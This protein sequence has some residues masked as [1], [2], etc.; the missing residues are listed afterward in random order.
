[1]GKG[2][3]WHQ[4]KQPRSATSPAPAV[5]VT[6]RPPVPTVSA[7]SHASG[8][9]LEEPKREVQLPDT[10]AFGNRISTFSRTVL[11]RPLRSY[12]EQVAAHILRS[13][14]CELGLTFTVMMSRQMGKNE[15]SAHIEAYLLDK[16]AKQGGEIVKAAPTFRPQVTTSMMRLEALL[17]R[18]PRLQK[19]WRKEHGYTIA[20]GE[21]RALFFSGEPEAAAMGATA[22]L[23]LEIDEAQDI[24][25]QKYTRDFRP[26]ASSTNATTVLWGTAWT[27][28]SL[29]EATKR[30]NVHL[31]QLDPT[32]RRHFELDWTHGAAE[33]EKYGK[34]VR[35]EIDRLG[36]THPLIKTQYL[37][38]TLGDQGAFFTKDNLAQLNGTHRRM[39]VPSPPDGAGSYYVAGVDVAGP[40]EEAT[41][42]ML[43][44]AYPRKDSTVVTVAMVTPLNEDGTDPLIRIQ[45]IYWWTG[46][47]LHEQCDQLAELLKNVWRCR[48]VVVDATGLGID[49]ATRLELALGKEVV[50]PFIFTGAS[51]SKLSY[52][53]LS[54]ATRARIQMWSE[55]QDVPEEALSPE[56]Q[57]FWKELK[58]TR[59]LHR[60]GGLL[61]YYVPDH[62]GHDDFV[63]SLALTAWA[64]QPAEITQETPLTETLFIYPE[65]EDVN[66]LPFY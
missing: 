5:S 28:D 36:E 30:H 19:R 42:A 23:L 47:P 35:S 26:M 52:H 11:A 20:L 12:Q 37:L 17:R 18:A 1:M 29:L 21:A 56:A 51:K 14:R 7:R 4:R 48:K 6:A 46:R 65:P 43:R 53:L 39:R 27:D 55:G 31:E 66:S 45:D 13:I 10:E 61:T 59:P 24:D 62:L 22:S 44:A 38:Q 33:N 40:A 9:R 60:S 64:V 41:D 15:L 58:L 57:E 63:S 49:I 16:Y 34:F 32:F 3:N 25:P 50:E 8:D 2:R 54:V